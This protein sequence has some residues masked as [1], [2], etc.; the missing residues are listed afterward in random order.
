MCE[1]ESDIDELR[2]VVEKQQEE[3]EELRREV[4][5]IKSIKESEDELLKQ[6]VPEG[7]RQDD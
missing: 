3:I 4:E 5:D 6:S 7:M 1:S 2:R